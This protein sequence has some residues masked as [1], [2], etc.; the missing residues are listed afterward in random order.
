MDNLT[1]YCFLLTAFALNATHG[2]E[3]YDCQTTDVTNCNITTCST[4]EICYAN[5]THSQQGVIFNMG[6]VQ[7][8][9]CIGFDGSSPLIGKRGLECHACCGKDLCNNALCG[10]IASHKCVDDEQEDCPKLN[11][12]FRI[13]EDVKH[14]RLICPRY[15]NL[16]NIVDGEWSAWSTWS[17]CSVTCSNGTRIRTRL[18]DNPAPSSQGEQCRGN[19]R[20]TITCSFK[21]CPV[22]GG[23][24]TWSSWGTC[25]ASCDIGMQRR[26]RYC[27][28]PYP[29]PDGDYCPG[30]SR[31]DRVCFASACANG[32]WSVWSS[33]SSCSLTCGYGLKSRQRR[34]DNPKPS[35]LGAYCIGSSEETNNCIVED[36]SENVV[37]RAHYLTKDHHS[38]G[39]TLIFINVDINEGVGYN[40]TTGVFTAPV[41]GTYSFSFDFC[42][43]YRQYVYYAIVCDDVT[44]NAGIFYDQDTNTCSSV[45]DTVIALTTGQRVWVKSTGSSY[46]SQNSYLWNSFSGTLIHT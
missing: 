3:C 45:A 35:V 30:D 14:A 28:N 43:Q 10:T 25:S 2:L 22:H 21:A 44:Q 16:C 15:C 41:N 17:S 24:T 23:W 34:C 1:W 42:C 32:N 29:S 39:E 13:C 27:S 4:G 38:S 6:C 5:A 20:E 11:S 9:K 8:S 19:D 26:D 46:F 36:C 37:F 31:D 12:L 7:D 33:W 40:E 18:C